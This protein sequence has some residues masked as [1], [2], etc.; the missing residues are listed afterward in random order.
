MLRL[1]AGALGAYLVGTIGLEVSAET[2]AII[3]GTVISMATTIATDAATGNLGMGTLISC[4]MSALSGVASVGANY[5]M[6]YAKG[7]ALE[8]GWMSETLTDSATGVTTQLKQNLNVDSLTESGQSSL[9]AIKGDMAH[10]AD[11]TNF[12]ANS[13]SRLQDIGGEG[14]QILKG[15]ST[16]NMAT[17]QLETGMAITFVKDGVEHLTMFTAYQT[18]QQAPFS[19]LISDLGKIAAP[20]AQTANMLSTY[21]PVK[22][23]YPET[24]SASCDSSENTEAAEQMNKRCHVVG[25]YCSSRVLGV[26]MT[27]KETSC[28]FSDMIGRILHEQGRKDLTSFTSDPSGIWGSPE[29]PNCRG[30]TQI[31]IQALNMGAIDW[32]EYIAKIQG[33]VAALA[34]AVNSY[35]NSTLGGIQNNISSI[36]ASPLNMMP[37]DKSS[38][39]PRSLA[40]P[41]FMPTT[42]TN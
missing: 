16:W 6:D 8:N 36:P 9:N 32:S 2:A 23:C 38:T 5:V 20:A 35:M 33:D 22:C 27:T 26:C 15:T 4:G 18:L 24:L 17:G 40:A 37:L 25:K 19:S 28:C 3:G 13:T 42:T 12:L 30:F 1:G 14:T 21:T 41:P 39:P 31:E 29:S 7:I 11:G 34:P 10:A